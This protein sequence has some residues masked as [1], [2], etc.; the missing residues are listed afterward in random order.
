M[1]QWLNKNFP[2]WRDAEKLMLEVEQAVRHFPRYHKYTLGSELRQL[3]TQ[4]INQKEMRTSWVK[5][6]QIYIEELKLKIQLA[7]SVQAFRAFAEFQSLVELA[8]SV[9]RQAHH[10]YKKL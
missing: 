10:W 9:A 2:I 6:L 5:R 4:S 7:K 3:A 1:Y 8:V